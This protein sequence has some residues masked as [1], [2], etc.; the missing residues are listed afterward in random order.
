MITIG[1]ISFIILIGILSW[2]VALIYA[3]KSISDDV[4]K[5]LGA[6]E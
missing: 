2:L 4:M 5:K 1:S 3:P 6:K